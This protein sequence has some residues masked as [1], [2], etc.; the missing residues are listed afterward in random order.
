MPSVT[1]PNCSP[2]SPWA[3]DTQSY[4]PA[5]SPN[6]T[7]VLPL[8]N[9]PLPDDPHLQN[10]SPG[11]L[12]PG[13]FGISGMKQ[14]PPS[15]PKAHVLSQK[16]SFGDCVDSKDASE[17]PHVQRPGPSPE[18]DV[19]LPSP[20]KSPP[21]HRGQSVRN[22]KM[23]VFWKES[24]SS[25]ASENNVVSKSP[26][27]LASPSA[28]S[29]SSTIA[30]KSSRSAPTSDPTDRS[31]S[32]I[33]PERCAELLQSSPCEIMLL[34]L[35]PYTR[36]AQATIRGSLNLCIPTTLLKRR[37]FDTQKLE[38]TFT[39]EAEKGSFSKWKHCRYIIVY[40]AATGIM[41]DAAPLFNVLNKFTAEGW[42]GE[43]LVLR[44]GFNAFSESFPGMTRLQ[45][46]RESGPSPNQLSMGGLPAVA[47]VAGG[48]SLPA[49]STVAVPFF[50]NIRQNTDLL[51]GV[52]QVA[53]KLP[54]RLTESRRKLL[55]GWLRV[56]SDPGN[57]GLNVSKKFLDLEKRE[58]ERM[59]EALS[60]NKTDESIASGATQCKRFRIAGIEKGSKNRYNDIYPFEHS[61]VRLQDVPSGNCDYV[62]ASHL[63][64]EPAEK[65]Y[66][67]TQ[68]PKPETFDVS[69]SIVT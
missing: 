20:L 60:Y 55:P 33:S 3:R 68:A 50:A 14:G 67:A 48:C 53:P 11:R 24:P 57:E 58:L 17:A 30:S 16:P 34:D 42:T 69:A 54:E 22:H 64:A 39:D 4:Q 59:R 8:C 65:T 7:P 1:G 28:L 63:R 27:A 19:S 66:I 10:L 25:E 15:S 41:K 62:N 36:F 12:S 43:G 40:D 13:Y 51:G 26:G 9:S 61:R 23:T 45:Q 52:G 31:D 5:G 37:S 46:S 38:A 44:G 18:G 49:S 32:M 21:R 56:A 35:R 2:T 47:P 6:P 29:M